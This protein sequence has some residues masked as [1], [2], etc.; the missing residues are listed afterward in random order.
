MSTLTFISDILFVIITSVIVYFP[1]QRILTYKSVSVADYALGIIYFFNCVPVLCDIVIGIPQYR[2]W[3]SAFQNTI[4]DENTCLIYNVYVTIVMLVVGILASAQT[5]KIPQ[6]LLSQT[7]VLS[8]WRYPGLDAIILIL[9]FVFAYANSGWMAFVGYE[10][11]AQRGVDSAVANTVNQLLNIS[12]FFAISRFFVKSR[13]IIAMVGLAIYLFLSI[14]LCGKR[15][16]IVNVLEMLFY[17]YQIRNI[18]NKEDKIN[19]KVWV[20]ISVIFILAFSSFYILNIKVTTT[21]ETL[22]STMRIDFGRDDVT[23]YAINK[24]LLLGE[25]IVEYP[26]ATFLSAIFMFVPRVFWPSK[27]YPHYRYLTASI[28]GTDVMSIPA[29]MTPSIFDMSICNFGWFGF[30]STIVVICG[31]CYCAD[32]EDR[33]ENKLLWL[34]ITTNVLTQSLDA[35]L[36]L[37][38][39]LFINHLFRRVK[40][41]FGSGRVR[42]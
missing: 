39:L 12:I 20:P 13:K 34:L 2:T 6:K 5:K 23:K 9:P 14:W 25:P 32:R 3:F 1:V 40:F 35:A 26:G 30:L 29:G 17:F 18:D 36:S 33:L 31:L 10:T 11:L 15:F 7:M 19:L 37:I 42:R 28:Y 27:P 16:I 21:M 38:V 8:T 41:T 4:A 22:Y 24:V